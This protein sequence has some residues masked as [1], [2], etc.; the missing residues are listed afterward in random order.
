MIPVDEESFAGLV[1]R[2][3]ELLDRQDAAVMRV[4]VMTIAS[5]GPV[6]LS[7]AD[8][9]GKRI[10]INSVGVCDVRLPQSSPVGTVFLPRQTNTGQLRFLPFGTSVLRNGLNHNGTARQYAAVSLT[11]ERNDDGNSAV[12]MLDGDTAAVG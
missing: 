1:A 9:G 6:D 12:W 7:T 3:E 8:H 4:V 11:C 10:R 5:P 2:F